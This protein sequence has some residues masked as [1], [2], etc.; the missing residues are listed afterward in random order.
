MNSTNFLDFGELPKYSSITP[1]VIEEGITTLLHLLEAEVA[2]VEAHGKADWPSGM[3]PVALVLTKLQ[4]VWGKVTHLHAVKNS[5]DLRDVYA[6]VQ[7]QVVQFGLRVSQS[8]KLFKLFEEIREGSYFS[9]LDEARKRFV[10]EWILAAHQAGVDLEGENLK[11]FNANQEQLAQLS[12]EFSNHVL[13]DVKVKGVVVFSEEELH[14][15]PTQVIDR[16]AQRGALLRE[17]PAGDKVG[18]VDEDRKVWFVSVDPTVSRPVLQHCHNQTLR[19]KLYREC[20]QIA[21]HG[22]NSNTTA[23][24]S[25]VRLKNSQ[26]NLLGY[27]S[28]AAMCLESR[29]AKTPETAIDF[30]ENLLKEVRPVALGQFEQI[31]EFSRSRGAG[32]LDLADIPYWSERLRE[33]RLGFSVEELRPYFPLQTVLGGLIEVIQI[34]FNVTIREASG[35]VDVWHP[36]V[37]YYLVENKNGEQVASF[38]FDPFVRPENK[39]GGAWMGIC[40][41]GYSLSNGGR[42]LPV[43]YVVCNQ[44]PVN[45]EG[46][47]LMTFEEVT[48]LFH[49]FGH[50]LH[51]M[52]APPCWIGTS[53]ME[54]SEW[55]SI[56]IES[57]FMEGWCYQPQVLRLI[58]G[59]YKTGEVLPDHL[60]AA[61]RKERSFFRGHQLVRQL[62]L[63]LTDLYLFTGKVTEFSEA[64]KIYYEVGAR[65]REVAPLPEDAMLCAFNHIFSGGYT[66]GYYSYLWSQ[67]LSADLFSAFSTESSPENKETKLEWVSRMRTIGVRFSETFFTRAGAVDPLVAFED[68]MGRK[69]ES[70][71][72]LADNG[73]G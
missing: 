15:T 62:H 18:G 27:P 49:E 35:G 38:Y 47:S 8:K 13:D 36:D 30:L 12:V 53:P 28:T 42:S 41:F 45:N 31:C 10:E 46:H 5:T 51:H 50:A 34:I 56:E 44:T 4:S 60:V 68:F 17:A 7:P 24:E 66:A 59:H 6:K 65:T 69:P 20:I 2:Q 33:D 63:A 71:A 57:Q 58:T 73:I 64:Q 16:C 48:T 9:T 11:I 39:R 43:A 19:R 37:R 25:I 23:L 21:G 29:L 32:D 70:G 67:V 61:L 72:F 22:G 26:A 14:G 1:K 55:D 54:L 40:R 52:L 3:E